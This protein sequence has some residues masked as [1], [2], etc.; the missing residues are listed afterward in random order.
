[1]S[2]NDLTSLQ[3]TLG[4]AEGPPEHRDLTTRMGFSYRQLLG[5]LIYAYVIF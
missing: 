4:P 3:Q 1:M 2:A 5:E